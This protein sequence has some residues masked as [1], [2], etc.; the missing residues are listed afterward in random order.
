MQGEE[1]AMR[2]TITATAATV[3]L[4]IGS[5][6]PTGAVDAAEETD[7]GRAIEG[8]ELADGPTHGMGEGDDALGGGVA[9]HGLE[10]ERGYL[11][12]DDDE[13]QY[14][15]V[16]EADES[17]LILLQLLGAVIVDGEGRLVGAVEDLVVDEDDR[18]RRVVIA[19]TADPDSGNAEAGFVIVP[20]GDLERSAVSAGEALV[21]T[22]DVPGDD[23]QRVE[24]Q[25]ERWRPVE[26]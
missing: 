20:L 15:Q 10:G 19:L 26:S 9:T 11:G 4:L 6:A 5:T 2:K 22:G 1:T 7:S 14:V 24:R 3:A 25:Y 18:V 17:D 21:L 13:R 12:L 16:D 23:H 8:E